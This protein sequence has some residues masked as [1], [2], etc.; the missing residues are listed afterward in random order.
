MN[1]RLREQDIKAQQDLEPA[2]AKEELLW[3]DKVR[4]RW[5]KHGNKNT[6]YSHKVTKTKGSRNKITNFREGNN[7]ITDPFEMGAHV[8]NCI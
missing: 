7:L 8:V 6:S 3:K 1:D 2:L 5:H 4:T